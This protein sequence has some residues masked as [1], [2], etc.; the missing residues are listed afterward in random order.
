[1]TK[2]LSTK[3]VMPI[4]ITA[5][6][7]TDEGYLVVPGRIART[8]IQ[9][10]YATELG[11]DAAYGL[12]PM[13]IIRLYRPEEEV[14]DAQSL[15]SFE[16]KPITINHPTDNVTAKNW[17]TLAK[18]EVKNVR[19]DGKYVLADLYIKSKDAIEAVMTGKAELSNGYMHNLDMT[20]GTTAEGQEYDGVMRN[21]RGNHVA[22]V[23]SARCGSACRIADL[24]PTNQGEATM[25]GT[26]KVTV[27]GIPLEVS[28]TAAA[29]INKLL[30]ERD[31]AVS[32][33][34]SA[35]D[36]AKAM[37][38][39][40]IHDAA[41]ATKDAEIEALKKDVMTPAQRD[42]MV[43]D[44]SKLLDD[45]KY[46]APEVSTKDKTCL[47]IRKEVIASVTAADA[48]VKKAVD[49]V[50]AGTLLE[51]A[52]V[53]TARKVFT[54]LTALAEP[55]S[56]TTGDAVKLGDALVG[57]SKSADEKL[58]G[59]AAMMQRQASLYKDED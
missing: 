19:Q 48:K 18:G 22:L 32:Q 37:V 16:N 8:G 38:S 5:R 34:T 54:M 53:D 1:M 7:F 57:G 46:L 41:L 3:D 29:T 55:Q 40:E 51:A 39:K 2:Q 15:A 49:A 24:N 31:E 50:L 43:A 14:F 27:D 33:F 13:K 44:W 30:K 20:A 9:N 4:D 10:Y 47:A 45:A 36:K 59:R 26:T 52:D 25:T 21:I 17:S 56:V 42:A 12:D 6:K 23:D 58:V 11:F 35:D 28:E